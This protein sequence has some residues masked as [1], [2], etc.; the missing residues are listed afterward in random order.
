M[1]FNVYNESNILQMNGY[2]S[3][4]IGYMALNIQTLPWPLKPN[5]IITIWIFDQYPSRYVFLL[6]LF[7]HAIYTKS[8]VTKFNLCERANRPD[9][10]ER[11]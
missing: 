7:L 10:S 1:S 9:W 5:R 8:E 4:D 6:F 11:P 3:R 2:K